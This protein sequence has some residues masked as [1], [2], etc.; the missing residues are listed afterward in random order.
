MNPDTRQT[1]IGVLGITAV[2]VVGISQGLNGVLSTTALLA[3]VGLVS[4]QVL[5]RLPVGGKGGR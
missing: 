5:D 1:L 2:T 4:P 3:I